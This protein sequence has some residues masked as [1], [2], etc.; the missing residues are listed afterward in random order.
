MITLPASTPLPPMDVRPADARMVSLASGGSVRLRSAHS[1]AERCCPLNEDDERL[2]AGLL[3][4]LAAREA[5]WHL[6]AEGQQ[7]DL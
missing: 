5:G 7:L 1:T 3:H 2:T 4:E 6:G